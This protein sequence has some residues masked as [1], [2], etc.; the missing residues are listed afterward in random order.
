MIPGLPFRNDAG[1]SGRMH[2]THRPFNGVAQI[3]KLNT[4]LAPQDYH[5][6]ATAGVVTSDAEAGLIYGVDP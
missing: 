3:T 6:T 5:V 4:V 2:C 1:P